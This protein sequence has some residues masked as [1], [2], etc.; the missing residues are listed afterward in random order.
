M[1]LSE[2]PN[3]SDGKS[4]WE[5]ERRERRRER[6]RATTGDEKVTAEIILIPL[7]HSGFYANTIVAGVGSDFVP[8]I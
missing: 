3:G 2:P 4:A 1:W 8:S 7:S 5:R 6:L